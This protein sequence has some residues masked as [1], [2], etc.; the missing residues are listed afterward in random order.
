MNLARI[1]A[2]V[3]GAVYTLVGIV[4]FLVAPTMAVATLIIFPVNV[5]HNA[6]HLLTGLAGLAAFATGR[7]VLY[8]RVV[9]VVFAVL[10]VV[11]LL[12]P[13]GFGLVP[14]GGADIVLHALTAILAAAAGWLYV[15][16]T[17]AS[18]TA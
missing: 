5:I 7:S 16:R 1:Y 11:G 17:Q 18:R 12:V 14:L 9:A 6:V 13:D 4:G 8:A 3:F 15:N 2:A 10:V